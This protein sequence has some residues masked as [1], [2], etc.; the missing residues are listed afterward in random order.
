MQSLDLM[1]RL[2]TALNP[3]FRLSLQINTFKLVLNNENLEKAE[4]YLK[5]NRTHIQKT[6]YE[7]GI[8]YC[9]FNAFL[10]YGSF[11]NN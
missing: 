9:N 5:F 4:L 2:I 7:L 1:M 3:G 11:Q 8:I 10:N 6:H